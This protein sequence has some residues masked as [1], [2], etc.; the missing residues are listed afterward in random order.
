MNTYKIIG[1]FKYYEN[2]MVIV[3]M[4]G[5][6]CIMPEREFNRIIETERKWN[7]EHKAA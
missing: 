1:K 4:N 7:K 5:A 6:A 2:T 3:M